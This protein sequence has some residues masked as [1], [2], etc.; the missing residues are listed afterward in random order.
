VRGSVHHARRKWAEAAADFRK[1]GALSGAVRDSARFFLWSSVARG[2]D[3]AGADQEL[4]ASLEGGVESDW[5]MTLARFLL[6]RQT[7]PEL[8]EAAQR[9]QPGEDPEEGRARQCQARY[10]AGVVRLL[11]GD[12]TGARES[13]GAC[14]A[15]GLTLATEYQ[16]AKAE[17][18]GAGI[19]PKN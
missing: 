14:E 18:A 4:I 5:T 1:A 3:R 19:D 17:L 6:G 8:L 15:S 2:G 10:Y 16:F 9:L 7:E 12:R 13:F 11:A